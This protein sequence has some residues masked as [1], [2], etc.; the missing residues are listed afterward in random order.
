MAARCRH[1]IGTTPAWQDADM[2]DHR[3]DP[4]ADGWT[5]RSP[6]PAELIKFMSPIPLAFGEDMPREDLEE[7]V[8]VLEHDRSFG[9]VSSDPS[10][11]VLGF[12]TAVPFR[13]TVPGG[14]V[15]VAGITGVAVRPDQRRR[16]LLTA[17][18]R[19]LIDDARSRREPAAVLWASEATI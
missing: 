12:A 5:V 14:E 9:A 2:T 10:S 4:A 17:L 8:K 7:W 19:R 1:A 3:P 6:S 16:G 15:P 18:M 11:Q 13:L